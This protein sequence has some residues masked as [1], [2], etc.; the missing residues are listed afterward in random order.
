MGPIKVSETRLLTLRVREHRER[1]ISALQDAFAHDLLDVEELE[2]RVTLAHRSDS[3]ADLDA[4][5]SDLALEE[6]G[7]RPSTPAGVALAVTPEARP[8][9]AIR[10]FMS[11]TTRSGP[12][13]VPRRLEVRALMSST[14]LDFR[15]ARFPPGVIELDLRAVMSSVEIIVPPGLPV[16]TEGSAILGVFDDVQRAP[17]TAEPD[18]PRL[19]VRGSAFMSAVEIR[20]RLPGET[21][22]EHRLRE[23]RELGATRR[24]LRS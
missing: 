10:G 16:E 23:R 24:Q 20:M 12:W 18:A 6:G 14:V 11:A 4:L 22:Q 9:Q 5:T 15:E 8:V 7:E 1:A 19:K 13:S 3:L 2:R 21:E 17:Q